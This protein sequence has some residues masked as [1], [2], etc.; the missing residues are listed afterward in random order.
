M[1]VK[2]GAKPYY[3]PHW[4]VAS[5]FQEPFKKELECLW[6]QQIIILLGI[7]ETSGM[8]NSIVLVPKLIHAGMP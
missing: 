2:E 6:E 3:T 1:E 8:C 4:H 7:D 5:A